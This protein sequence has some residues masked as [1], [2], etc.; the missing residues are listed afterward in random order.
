MC[1]A[2]NT[3]M[4]VLWLGK[5][6]VNVTW[7]PAS[8]LPQAVVD[9]FEKGVECAAVQQNNDFYGQNT[10]TSRLR[11][12]KRPRTDRPVIQSNEVWVLLIPIN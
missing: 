1:V 4:Q 6:D 5:E 3:N 12:S 11:P 7:E 2:L 10:Y 8:S 9:E